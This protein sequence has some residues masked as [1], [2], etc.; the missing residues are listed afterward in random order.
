MTAPRLRPPTHFVHP[1]AKLYWTVR[2]G[3]GWLGLLVVE[4]VVWVAASQATAA[5][6]VVLAVT[7]VLAAV[8]LV[9]MPRW[10]YRLHRWEATD[11]AVY[12]QRGWLRVERR[13]APVSRVQTVDTERGPLEQVFG[14]TSVTITT[15]S[16][17]GP[18]TIEGLDRATADH[19]VDRVTAVTA[20]H[21]G[22]AT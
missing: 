14:L 2:A 8:H 13:I 19:L 5:H 6:A 21:P 3:V 18:L 1:R 9:V 15:A 4:A 12:T 16:A 17:A 7:V 10:R 11:E 22:D 20:A